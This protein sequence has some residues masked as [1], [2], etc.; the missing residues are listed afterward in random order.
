MTRIFISYRRDDTKAIA[1][2][3]YDRL[4]S[5]IGADN[6]FLDV[7][8]IPPGVDFR[9]FLQNAIAEADVVLIIIG[10]KWSEILKQRIKDPNDFVRI[11]LESALEQRKITIPVL[12]DGAKMPNASDLPKRVAAVLPFLN[13]A[14]LGDGAN[15]RRDVDRLIV[16]LNHPESLKPPPALPD[17]HATPLGVVT[18]PLGNRRPMRWIVGLLIIAVLVGTGWVVATLLRNSTLTPLITPTVATQVLVQPSATGILELATKVSTATAAPTATNTLRPTDTR[19][20]PT[21]TRTL[22]PTNTAVPPTRGNFVTFIAQ[23]TSTSSGPGNVGTIIANMRATSAARTTDVYDQFPNPQSA[24]DYMDRGLEFYYQNLFDLAIADYTQAI[25][26]N[27]QYVGAY[28]NRGLAYKKQNKLSEAIA[29][30]TQAIA[31]DPQYARAY[32]NRGVAYKEQ[33]KLTEAIADYTQAITLDPQ[34]ALAYN[35]RGVIYYNQGKY[36]EAIA[37]YTQAITLDSEYTSAYSNRGWAYYKQGSPFTVLSA[38]ND[39]VKAIAL[40]P[41]YANPYWGLGNIYYDQKNNQKALENYQKYVQLIGLFADPT[42][43]ERIKE[44]GG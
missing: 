13:A 38:T 27:P 32:N 36:S 22:P 14:V 19:I 24:S 30:Y 41:E 10:P 3:L 15:F 16:D 9:A 20:P 4:E 8:H 6:L 23:A 12:V 35:N 33:G 11:E 28:N 43:R 21:F 18:K 44:L 17:I 39:F 25:T 2:R 42:V 7:D 26:L 29:D 1:G 5:A 34:Y 37:D 31:L 40:D